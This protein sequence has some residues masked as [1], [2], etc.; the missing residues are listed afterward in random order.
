MMHPAAL[1]IR[2]SSVETSS[3]TISTQNSPITP[4]GRIFPIIVGIII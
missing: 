1:K 3:I 2:L 4:T